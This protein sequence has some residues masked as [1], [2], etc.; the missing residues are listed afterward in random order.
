MSRTALTTPVAVWNSTDRLRTSRR[1]S[2]ILAAFHFETPALDRIERDPHPVRQEIERHGGQDDCKR[3]PER[4]PPGNGEV[5]AP[6]RDHKA[7]RVSRWPD[8]YHEEGQTD[9]GEHHSR[10]AGHGG[11]HHS[12]QD[13]RHDVRDK[14]RRE[15]QG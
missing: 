4:Q 5:F 6:K 3:R 2:A 8:A 10:E 11:S 14:N 7:P 9:S 1:W 15:G 13:D 12:R